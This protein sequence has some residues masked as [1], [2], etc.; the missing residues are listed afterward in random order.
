MLNIFHPQFNPF[1]HLVDAIVL[2]ARFSQDKQRNSMKHL[3]RAS[4]YTIFQLPNI[5]IIEIDNSK[6]IYLEQ[7][8]RRMKK[9]LFSK[10]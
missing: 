2:E 6:H 8:Y 4:W 5:P 10:K 3:S 9:A 7:E 1:K